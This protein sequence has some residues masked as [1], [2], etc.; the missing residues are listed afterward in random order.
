MIDIPLVASGILS[1]Q[2]K[3][4]IDLDLDPVIP[5]HATCLTSI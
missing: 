3:I 4:L 2:S 1:R 5:G